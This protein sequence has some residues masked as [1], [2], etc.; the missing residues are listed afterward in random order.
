[1][2]TE[3]SLSAPYELSSSPESRE[4]TIEEV[5]ESSFC[6]ELAFKI[7]ALA[8]VKLIGLLIEST[9]LLSSE[10]ELKEPLLSILDSLMFPFGHHLRR[11]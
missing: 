4:V 1:M 8:L 9:E 7:L 10:E 5:F 11:A 2:V 6:F 3:A